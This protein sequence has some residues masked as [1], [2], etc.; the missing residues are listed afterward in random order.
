MNHHRNGEKTVCPYCGRTVGIHGFSNS[1]LR[2]PAHHKCPHGRICGWNTCDECVKHVNE[3]E[4]TE[5]K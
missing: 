5:K 2:A 4:L 3:S 1:R